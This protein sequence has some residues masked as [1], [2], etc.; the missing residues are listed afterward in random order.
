VHT[1]EHVAAIEFQQGIDEC[2]T[3]CE[4]CVRTMEHCFELRGKRVNQSQLRTLSDCVAVC[5]TTA[6]FMM[7]GSLFHA[8]MSG[9]CAEVCRECERE[10][11]QLADD[12]KMRQCAEACRRC[13]EACE[14]IVGVAA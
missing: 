2:L 1:A 3:C 12:E 9:L 6:G 14:R 13:A 5:Q 4:V 10:C 8:R 7:R 11:R